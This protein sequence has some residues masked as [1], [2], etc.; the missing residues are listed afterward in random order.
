MR[1]LPTYYHR[2]NQA[3]TNRRLLHLDGDRNGGRV[4]N[5]AVVSNVAPRYAPPG[6]ALIASTVLC[7]HDGLESPVRGHAAR[8]HGVDP[9]HWEH[10]AMYP[11]SA[12]LPAMPAGQA[13]RQPVD[14]GDGI[15][16]A[17]DH[18]DTPSIQGALASGHRAAQAIRGYLTG[19]RRS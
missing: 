9:Q 3:P 19:T 6:I 2:T 14:L 4:I 8:I 18:R 5:T 1:A 15:F 12:A 10:V 17:G 16:V 7:H 11:I 13:L